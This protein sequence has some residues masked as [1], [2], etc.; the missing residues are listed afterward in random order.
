MTIRVLL[1]DDHAVLREGIAALIEAED[2]LS[3]VGQ[4]ANADAAV[5]LCQ[6]LDPDVAVVDLTM[7]GGGLGAVRRICDSG[8]R[9]R[10]LVLTMHDDPA[11]LRKVLAAGGTGYLVKASASSELIDALRAVAR[12]HSFIRISVGQEGLR[13]VA[14]PAEGSPLGELSQREREVLAL[15]ARG[16]TN[17][18]VAER[19]GVH[20]KTVDT[21]RTRLQNK[22]GSSSRAELFEY[23][24][25]A[26]L[27]G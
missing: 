8:L 21:Y 16:H 6:E 19:L 22:L 23:A 17:R 3:V 1:A 26:G 15:L 4:A 24:Q 12:G 10:V 20:K 13:D 14:G 11:Y 7:P 5:A 2:D 27:L 18:E 25:K 9:T